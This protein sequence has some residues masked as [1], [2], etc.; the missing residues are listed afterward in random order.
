MCEM[1]RRT[2]AE[3]ARHAAEEH[4]AA[5]VERC[6]RLERPVRVAQTPR[7]HL[8][9]HTQTNTYC[10]TFTCSVLYVYV[11]NILGVKLLIIDY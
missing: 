3:R 5:R 10:I 7:A 2:R 6:V 8:H 1:S 9:L 4:C 11:H